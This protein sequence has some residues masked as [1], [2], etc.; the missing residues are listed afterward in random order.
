MIDLIDPSAMVFYGPSEL[1]GSS[2][3][4]RIGTDPRRET[5]THPYLA[6]MMEGILGHAFSTGASDCR[7][8]IRSASDV[9]SARAAAACIINRIL[10]TS[11]MLT[12]SPVMVRA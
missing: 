12:G 8:I 10:P 5:E 4:F 11:Q 3:E 2:R 1:L 6:A 7:F 9:V